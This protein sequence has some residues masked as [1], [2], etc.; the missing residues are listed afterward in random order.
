MSFWKLSVLLSACF[1]LLASKSHAADPL[2]TTSTSLRH[3]RISEMFTSY[4]NSA[5]L[6]SS[7]PWRRRTAHPRSYQRYQQQQQRYQQDYSRRFI[8]ASVLQTDSRARVWQVNFRTRNIGQLSWTSRLVYANVLAFLAQAM[9]PSLTQWGMKLSDRILQ[10]QEL[11]RLITPVFLHG[12][13]LHLFTNMISLQRTGQ[14][15]EKLMGGGLY[16]ATYL[17][18]GVAGNVFSAYKSPNPSLGASGAVFGVF[19]AY[20]VFLSRNDWIMGSYGQAMTNS[21]IQ[22]MGMNLFLGLMNPVIDNWA[23]LGG[24]LGGA[25]MAYVFGPRLY[26][27]DLPSGAGRFVIDRPIARL[28]RAVEKMAVK[29]QEQVQ[30]VVGFLPLVGEGFGR[31]G[32]PWQKGNKAKMR[33]PTPNK[34]IKPLPVP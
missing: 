19:G 25:A 14:D 15:L 10:G 3:C 5:L 30:R 31:S 13:V 4:H 33:V 18:A 9:R 27:A 29:T 32:K 11:H 16:L 28:P 23:H 24:A 12:G 21:I 17:M 34:S 20:F 2:Y 8:D 26:L 22:T 1:S 6:A 7:Q